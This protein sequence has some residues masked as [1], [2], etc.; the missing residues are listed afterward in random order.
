MVTSFFFVTIKNK[1]FT[2]FNLFQV[3]NQNP[4]PLLLMFIKG[5]VCVPSC[6]RTR[7]YE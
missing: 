6:A 4:E 7:L 5:C 3:Q 1:N 2:E